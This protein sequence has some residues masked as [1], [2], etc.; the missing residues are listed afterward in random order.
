MTP[1]HLTK[2][3]KKLKCGHYTMV[4]VDI[5]DRDRVIKEYPCQICLAKKLDP[6]DKE[7]AIRNHTSCNTQKNAPVAIIKEQHTPSA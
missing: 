1:L 6:I 5:D 7:Y 3:S 4:D 2:R